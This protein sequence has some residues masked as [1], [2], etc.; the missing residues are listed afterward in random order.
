MPEQQA[1]AGAPQ[2][3]E[4]PPIAG[5]DIGRTYRV[6][7]PNGEQGRFR[8]PSDEEWRERSRGI[9]FIEKSLGRG[10][11]TSRA[12]GVDE[13][14]EWLI[15]RIIVGDG[16]KPADLGEIDASQIVDVVTDTNVLD[17]ELDGDSYRIVMRVTG[18]METIHR[19]RTPTT[20][21]RR[22]Y[23]RSSARTI[24]TPSGSET[25][26]NIDAT[27]DLYDLLLASV[28]GYA[29]LQPPPLAHKVAA[30]TALIGALSEIELEL[31]PLD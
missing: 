16:A 21:E 11:S 22:R 24:N 17:C 19:L 1:A 25:R 12:E 14:D 13:A 5:F 28:E 15:E 8:F 31:D 23:E 20:K 7:F 18:G 26:A 6:K 4:K 29:E 30:V 9:K 2:T 3:S 10:K 27:G